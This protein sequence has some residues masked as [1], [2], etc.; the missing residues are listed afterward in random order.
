MI[1]RLPPL[2]DVHVHMR[3]PGGEHKET[4]ETGTAAA[5][6]G[7][8]STVLA[9]PNTSPG[10]VDEATLQM[11][12]A[13]ADEGARCDYAQYLGAALDNAAEAASLAPRAAGLKMYLGQTFGDLRLD[14]ERAWREHLEAWPED[15]VVAV[16]AEGNTLATVLSLAAAA[17][18]PI[19]ICHVATGH[20][21]GLI[22]AVR[23]KGQRV[24]CEAAPHHLFLDRTN[25][26]SGGRAEVRPRLGSPEDRQALWDHLEIIDCFATDHAPHL[27]AE[28]DAS[29]PP[30]GFPGLEEMLPLLVTAVHSGML[31]M[32]DLV[33][34]LHHNPMRIYGIEPPPDTWTEIDVDAMWDIG[35]GFSKAGWTPY[36]GLPVRG[37]VTRVVLRGVTAFEDGDVVAAPGSGR[38]ITTEGDR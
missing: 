12:L 16:H 38:D 6:A 3:Q 8:I 10:V 19:H 22:A 4:W 30:P 21:I 27:L 14:D 13:S 20:D 34:R 37:K 29:D 35:P 26:P 17:E 15:S 5:L 32:E 23:D 31:T 1:E 2:I 25:A 7:G 33:A 24:T 28:K 9:M 11:A 18:R 36:E